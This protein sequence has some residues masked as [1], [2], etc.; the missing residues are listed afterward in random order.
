MPRHAIFLVALALML[1]PAVGR[2]QQKA[3]AKPA[4]RSASADV[5]ATVTYTGKGKVDDTHEI[6]VFLFDTP[7]IGQGS[8]P[9]AVQ[10]IRK[11]GAPATFKAVT[12]DPVYI[13]VAYDE[14]GNYD[15]N[16]GPPP[17]GTPIAMY[18]KDGKTN[19][20]V[21]PGPAAKIKLSFDDSRRMGG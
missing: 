18:S 12:A 16:M 15:G 9:I 7:D 10:A 21:K 1:G 13:A 6:W 19:T 11:S 17:S 5:Q 2:A 20:P 8:R 14:T 4:A 3:P